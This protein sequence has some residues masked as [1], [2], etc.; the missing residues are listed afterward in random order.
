MKN[1]RN[2]NAPADPSQV[3]QKYLT[4]SWDIVTSVYN[5]LAAL[6]ALADALPT[7]TGYLSKT[8]IDTLAELNAIVT[9][10]T[11]GDFATQAQAEAGTDNTVTMTPLRTA[12]AIAVLATSLKNKLD[13]TTAPT[14]TDDSSAGYAAGSYW[15]DVTND[16]SYRCVDSTASAAIWVKT[17]LQTTDLATVAVSGDSD[18]LVQGSTQ[19]LMTAAERT[20][21]TGIET[22]ATADQTDLQ[23]ETAYNNQVA[24]VSAGERTAG[25]EAAIRRFYPWR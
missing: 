17:T 24:A 19:L 16:E 8:D 2:A 14:A 20:K 22:A 9:D 15:I 10:A 4:S 6:T 18:D 25:T 5:E 7:L 23:I 12:Q 21:L 3:V 13:G 1:L 11:F